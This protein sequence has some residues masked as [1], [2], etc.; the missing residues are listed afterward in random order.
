MPKAEAA[1]S[2]RTGAAARFTPYIAPITAQKDSIPAPHYEE[3]FAMRGHQR[4][5]S[6]VKFS[7]CGR[8]LASASADS[9]VRLW[10][11]LTG[12]YRCTLQGAHSA[13]VNDVA[14]SRDSRYLASCSDDKTIV[15]WDVASGRALKVRQGLQ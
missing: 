5:V 8:W 11:P 2:F 4:S 14:W 9:T 12:E 3:R 7:P 15:I 10:Q 1:A 13:G 6:C